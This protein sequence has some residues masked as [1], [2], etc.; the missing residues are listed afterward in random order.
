MRRFWEILYLT[1]LL[2]LR[3]LGV[4]GLLVSLLLLEHRLGDGNVIVGGDA[5]VQLALRRVC[6][7]IE[8]TKCGPFCWWLVGCLGV[9]ETLKKQSS[10]GGIEIHVWTL[11]DAPRHP[12]ALMP[13]SI[14]PLF[15]AFDIF[16]RATNLRQ[17]LQ[18]RQVQALHIHILRNGTRRRSRKSSQHAPHKK[19]TNF[20]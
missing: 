3:S 15:A 20:I 11:V 19:F 18:G 4:G 9:V 10:A 7:G 16:L 6:Y 12:A 13:R 2:Q 8:L 14:G 5:E 17:L 1:L